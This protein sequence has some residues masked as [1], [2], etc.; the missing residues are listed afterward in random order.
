MGAGVRKDF[1]LAGRRADGGF[2]H[3]LPVAQQG[4]LLERSLKIFAPRNFNDATAA[5][6]R[7]LRADKSPEAIPSTD[8]C[9]DDAAR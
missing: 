8:R 5:C 7:N 1:A 9:A 4:D 2:G 3:D 6:R